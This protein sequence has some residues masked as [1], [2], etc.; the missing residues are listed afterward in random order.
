MSTSTSGA[1]G[2]DFGSN[3]LVISAVKKGGVDTL[4]NEGSHRETQNVI[5]FGDQERFI[6]E[7]GQLQVPFYTNFHP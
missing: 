3:T 2:L 6:G 5:G 7:P 1:V 4:T